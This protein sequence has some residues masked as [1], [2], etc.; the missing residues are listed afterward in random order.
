MRSKLPPSFTNPI[1]LLGVT[2][3]TFCF[4]VI[5]FL[6]INEWLAKDPS[7]YV[8][9]L[10]Y[11]IMPGVLLFGVVIAVF[12]ILR[13]NRLIRIGKHKERHFPSIDLGNPRH[14][15][16]IAV[17]AV[18]GGFLVLAT[19]V[20]SF[21]A[22]HAMETD[23]FC[24]TSCHTPMEPEYT[25][26]QNGPHA[27]VGC[28]KCHIG[29][30]AGWFVKSKLSGSYQLYSVA[31]N[32]FPRPIETPIHNLRPAQQ[33]CEQCHW[34]SQ[35]F[36]QKLMRQT[37]YSSVGDK[38]VKSS[39]DLL[40]K[41]GGGNKEAGPTSGIH[42]HMNIR[43]KVNY[44]ATD[45]RRQVIPWVRSEGPDGK[46]RI[47]KST[48]MPFTAQD[49]A[50]GESRRMDC[51]DCHN[52][53]AHQYR[54]PSRMVNHLMT[55]GWIDPDLPSAKDLSVHVLEES[56][57]TAAIAK[58]SIRTA[59]TEYYQA[60]FPALVK[61][62]Q[63]SIERMIVETQNLFAKNYFPSMRADWKNFPDNIGHMYFP[64]CFRCHDGKHVDQD[65]KV[66]TKDCNTCHSIIGQQAAGKKP[67]T[68]LEGLK[69]VHPVDIGTDWMEGTCAECHN[70]PPAKKETEKE[71]AKTVSTRTGPAVD[72]ARAAA[73]HRL[74]P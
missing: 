29:S 15:T 61:T 23:K 7:P 36:S 74:S 69:Y 27:R 67:E 68:S 11:I 65:G 3:T 2:I 22:Y 14:Q 60:N 62:K 45:T 6:A 1:T 47:F 41:V 58:D 12:G 63:A 20:G 21:Q 4:I 71:K 32:K 57:S 19:G 33:T 43:N 35:F 56:Y 42:W 5:G 34:P 53:P 51:V 16:G 25:A 37:Y 72:A 31:F 13:E 66:L 30:G 54:N 73:L 28:V 55:L 39:I 10:A 46:V 38:N 40:I 52:R 24:G 17:V 48:E 59:I 18:L 26:Y 50:N 44:V 64:G 8:G 9:V 49:S 70:T